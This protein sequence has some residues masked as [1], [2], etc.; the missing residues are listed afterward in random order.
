MLQGAKS[1]TDT[2]SVSQNGALSDHFLFFFDII[3][4]Y[5]VL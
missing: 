3:N 2:R 5:K 1:I 4:N